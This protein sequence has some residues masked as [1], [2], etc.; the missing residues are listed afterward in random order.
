MNKNE[1]V[2]REDGY[3]VV[4]KRGTLDGPFIDLEDA[5]E[6]S[7]WPCNVARPV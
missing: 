4:D 6:A 2:K 5:V 7:S 1:I 3:W